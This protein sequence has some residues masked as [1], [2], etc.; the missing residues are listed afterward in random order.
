MT[1]MIHELN[2]PIF[3]LVHPLFY[4]CAYFIKGLVYALLA[5]YQIWN[6]ED[7]L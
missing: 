1:T 3:L 5:Y 6:K 4:I 7:L 2:F